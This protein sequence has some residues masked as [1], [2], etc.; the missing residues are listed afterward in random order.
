MLQ[1]GLSFVFIFASISLSLNPIDGRQYLPGFVA[2]IIPAK[3]F[4]TFFGIYEIVL[5]MWLLSGKRK[6]YSGFA[7]AITIF[8]ITVLNLQSFSILFRNVAI[9]FAGLSLGFM[10]IA[11]KKKYKNTS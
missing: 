5:S 7:A 1:I 9:L 8:L 10:G 4:L 2:A 6:E 3:I 11:H